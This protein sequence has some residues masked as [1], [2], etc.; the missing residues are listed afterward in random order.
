MT[1]LNKLAAPIPAN[2]S[3]EGDLSMPRPEGQCI[4]SSGVFT[5]DL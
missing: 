4:A 5:A 2:R 1:K 3:L